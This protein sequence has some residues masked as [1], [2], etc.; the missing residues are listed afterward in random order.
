MPD[1]LISHPWRDKGKRRFFSYFSFDDHNGRGR[2]H[3]GITD[4]GATEGL[5][6]KMERKLMLRRRGLIDPE[7]ELRS[8]SQR[9]PTGR[10]ELKR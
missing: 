8:K 1:S 6:A 10:R 4:K 7:N 2:T 3:N 5:V 9:A